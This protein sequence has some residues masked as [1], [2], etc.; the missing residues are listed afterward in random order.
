[1]PDLERETVEGFGREWSTFDQSEVPPGELARTFERYFEVFPWEA[2]P[3]QATGFDLGCGSGRWARF[4]APRVA[5][6]HCIDPS[7][8]ALAVARRNLASFA[9]CDFHLAGVDAMPLDD[10]SMD[11]GYA[12]GVLHHVPDTERALAAAVAK[13]K[14]GAPLLVYL[15]YA[16]ENRPAWYRALWRLSDVLRRGLA[17]LPFTLR[18]TVTDLVAALLYW[19][20]ARLAAGLERLGMGVDQV[21]LAAYRRASFYTMRTDAL[22]RLG[23]R[24]ER[25]FSRAEIETMMAAAG[26]EGV[27]FRE[28]P[29][30]WCA[31]GR[32]RAPA[33]SR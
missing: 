19:P 9:N 1:M 27:R 20:L 6:L 32:R 5:R 13:L 33:R 17:R 14:P 22:D 8:A 7:A 11:F 15:Y 21:P 23:T 29:P 30:Y 26:L 25:R 24:L 12:L 28:G 4:V 3:P 10:D 16:L 18:R 31:V 2:L